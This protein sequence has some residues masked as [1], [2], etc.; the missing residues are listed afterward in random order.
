MEIL[1]AVVVMARIGRNRRPA[2]LQTSAV[3]TTEVSTTAPRSSG[4]CSPRLVAY[5]VARLVDRR[6]PLG[7]ADRCGRSVEGLVHP[8]LFVRDG[9]VDEPVHSG[10]DAAGHQEDRGERQREPSP[11]RPPAGHSQQA[12]V[13][14]GLEGGPIQP[15]AATLEHGR[16]LV[17]VAAGESADPGRQHGKR[18][19]LGQVVIG[20]EREPVHLVLLGA[21]GGEH[22]HGGGSA[23]DP[24][25]HVIAGDVRK[26]PIEDH[27]VV[28]V[29]L[30][31]GQR[32][33]AVGD[34]VD[35]HAGRAEPVSDKVRQRRLVLDDQHPH[36]VRTR[37]VRHTGITD[38]VIP[39]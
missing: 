10:V 24:T 3:A 30:A 15:D 26:A 34:D 31:L 19:G 28:V 14:P 16:R 2:A 11:K 12:P 20:A 27:D 23:A 17:D 9:R 22:Q 29:D 6:G 35:R 4:S 21:P 36:P 25:A 7:G 32:A 38:P 33:H 8:L 5:G 37:T 13:P 18:E 39:R 1:R